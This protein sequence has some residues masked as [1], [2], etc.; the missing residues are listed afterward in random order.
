MIAQSI[1]LPWEGLRDTG[2]VGVFPKTASLMPQH[3]SWGPGRAEGLGCDCPAARLSPAPR[4]MCET[5][6]E[7]IQKHLNDGQDEGLGLQNWGEKRAELRDGSSTNQPKSTVGLV[8]VRLFSSLFFKSHGDSL[9]CGPV[10]GDGAAFF[11]P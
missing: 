10:L 1:L 9:G 11:W 6:R 4:E 8:L 3:H 5:E 2:A 7:H